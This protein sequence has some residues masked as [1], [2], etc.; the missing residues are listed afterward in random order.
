MKIH[1][2]RLTH[3]YIG[4]PSHEHKSIHWTIIFED[5]DLDEKH[6][7][8]FRRTEVHQHIGDEVNHYFNGCRTF[9]FRPNQCKDKVKIKIMNM[10]TE[11]LLA[12]EEPLVIPF[13]APKI[14]LQ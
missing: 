8:K 14:E 9:Q 10:I 5:G 12:N 13:K 6:M 3:Q 7:E 11:F 1:S 4:D 2:K